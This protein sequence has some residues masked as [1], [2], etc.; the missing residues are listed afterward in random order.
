MPEIPADV[1]TLKELLAR[2]DPSVVVAALRELSFPLTG[3]L[4]AAGCTVVTFQDILFTDKWERS[5]PKDGCLVYTASSIDNNNIVFITP[6][7]GS[8]KFHN[9]D[10]GT[11]LFVCGNAVHLPPKKG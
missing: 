4:E 7:G 10:K 2:L 3:T 8:Q 6:V 9:F 5:E 1:W 11:E